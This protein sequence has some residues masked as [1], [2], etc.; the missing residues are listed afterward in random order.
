MFIVFVIG[1]GDGSVLAQ[2][3]FAAV[4]LGAMHTSHRGPA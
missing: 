2:S 4:L 3:R 1:A